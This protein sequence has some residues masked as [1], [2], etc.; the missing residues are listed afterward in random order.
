LG[1]ALPG[2]VKPAKAAERIGRL[3]AML[4]LEHSIPA[5]PSGRPQL[6]LPPV[7]VSTSPH[8]TTFV[9]RARERAVSAGSS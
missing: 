8:G 5:S 7:H 2:E 9:C 3:L 1:L 6:I 4:V